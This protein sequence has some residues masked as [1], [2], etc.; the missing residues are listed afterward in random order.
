ML[1]R[2]HALNVEGKA[3]TLGIASY[4]SNGQSFTVHEKTLNNIRRE[5]K[6]GQ[7][8]LAS[9]KTY[10]AVARSSTPNR[11]TGG[12]AKG[13]PGDVAAISKSNKEGT[14]QKPQAG[15]PKNNQALSE[16]ASDRL[17]EI[18]NR[19]ERRLSRVEDMMQTVLS[20]ISS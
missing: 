18:L 12:H 20:M 9:G 19:L 8:A 10:A 6:P 11:P 7:R 16:G 1:T 5:L 13:R 15:E 2:S 17:T 14:G 3:I 4:V